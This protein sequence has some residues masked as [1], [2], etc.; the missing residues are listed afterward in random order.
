MQYYL[1]RAPFDGAFLFLEKIV[2]IA[3]AKGV[4]QTFFDLYVG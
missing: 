4:L 2:E 3:P 1:H